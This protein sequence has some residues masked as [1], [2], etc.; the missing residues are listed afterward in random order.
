MM[1][2]FVLLLS[3]LVRLR[4]PNVVYDLF[5]VKILEFI[6]FVRYIASLPKK[7]IMTLYTISKKMKQINSTNI[8]NIY[9]AFVRSLPG[10]KE[11]D[12]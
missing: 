9:L 10:T 3:K 12:R 11:H 8:T 2:N 1:N 4:S 7:L 5:N 6:L